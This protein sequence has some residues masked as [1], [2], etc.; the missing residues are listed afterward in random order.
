MIGRK[1]L[2]RLLDDGRKDMPPALPVLVE[3][4]GVAMK[5][6]GIF[7]MALALVTVACATQ[8]DVVSLD[9]RLGEI[10]M[11]E[12]ELKREKAALETQRLENEK[13]LRQQTASLRATIAELSEEV[14]ALTG[15]I[16]EVEHRQAQQQ[17][18]GSLSGRQGDELKTSVA[19]SER[20]LRRIE[21]YL[22]LESATAAAATGGA[23]AGSASKIQP[24]DRPA[25]ALSDQALYNRAKQAFDQGDSDAARKDFETFIARYPKSKNADNA[26]FW[27]GEIYYRDKWYEKAI[28]EY[29]KVIEIYPDGNKVPAALLKQGLAFNN[30]G[31]KAN[32]RLILEELVRK[33]PKTNEAEVASK[34]LQSL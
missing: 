3:R 20:R 9:S 16:E 27:I 1:Q 25:A 17:N 2:S 30:I 12:A 5:I 21:E 28:L 31:D 8:R 26:Q 6:S 23:A 18:E 10:E 29:Q 7:A 24:V 32:A 22:N 15:R 4:T 34:K 33:Y 13:A 14:R 19:D 11:R